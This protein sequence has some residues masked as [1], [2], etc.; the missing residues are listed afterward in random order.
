MND[1]DVFFRTLGIFTC[2]F[3]ISFFIVALYTN[4]NNKDKKYINDELD[5]E[6]YY[7]T[8][9][10]DAFKELKNTKLSDVEMNN[11][12][13]LYLLENTPDG[14]VIINYN[15]DV[16]SFNYWCDNKNIKYMVLNSVVHKYAIEYNCKSVCIDYKSEYNKA[17]KE[18]YDIEKRIDKSEDN[19]EDKSE[20]KSEEKNVFVKFK[21]YKTNVSDNKPKYLLTK[22]SN[23]FSYKGTIEEYY[24]LVNEKNK[25]KEKKNISYSDFKK[26]K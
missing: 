17:L 16:E 19:S 18:M 2:S 11:L 26:I 5:E 7:E 4:K 10:Y 13:E 20:D 25:L 21:N 6:D 14:D 23:R 8:K 24:K 15:N 12:K 22:Y 1:L 3:T 9:Y